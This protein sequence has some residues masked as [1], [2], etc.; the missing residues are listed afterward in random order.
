MFPQDVAAKQMNISRPTFTRIYDK[1]LKLIAKSFIEGKVIDIVGGNFQFDKEWYR[2]KN[3]YRLIQ[4]IENHTR[5]KDCT[6]YGYSEL[7]KLN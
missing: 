6:V 1:T 7:I 5:C 2:C 3:C 4:G